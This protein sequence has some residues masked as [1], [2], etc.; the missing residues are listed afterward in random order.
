MRII[1]IDYSLNCPAVSVI[2]DDTTFEKSHHYYLTNTKKYAGKFDNITGRM[3]KPYLT[4]MQR[5]LGIA[6][7]AVYDTG[8]QSD[9]IVFLE[10]YSM[11]S[12]GRIFAIAENTAVL[13]YLL[14]H[15]CISYITVPPT[16]LKKYF[17]GKGNADKEAMYI[18]FQ[19]KT[20]ED[21]KQRF[22]TTAKVNNPITDIVDAFALGLY[23][24]DYIRNSS[25]MDIYKT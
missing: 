15:N 22:N 1:G 21:L 6:S 13:K 7:W 25:K 12:T 18:A 19:E 17:Q 10:D 16:T 20:G 24:H 11:G 14:Y 2:A 8:L 5:Y 4:E 23:G 3:H 9:D